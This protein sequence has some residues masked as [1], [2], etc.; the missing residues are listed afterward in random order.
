MSPAEA[1]SN[2]AAVIVAAGAGRRMGAVT[3]KQYLA[4]AGEPI[5]FH[6]LRAFDACAVIGAITLVAPVDELE[7][8][9]ANIVAPLGLATPVTLCPGGRERQDSVRL[10]LAAVDA[11]H[12]LVAIHDGVRP[13]IQSDQI[14][15]CLAAAALHGAALLAI[16]VSDTL[17][18]ADH[19]RKVRKTLPRDGVWLAQ[20]PQA[21]ER[22][23]IVAA[24]QRADADGIRGTDDAALVERLGRSV[25]LVNGSRQNIKVTTPEDLTL[26]EAFLGVSAV[27]PGT[28]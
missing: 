10:G 21:F 15:A 6:T 12:R 1:I 22:R 24:H 18:L 27:R 25:H 17:K 7:W 19:D 16:P 2:S 28:Y 20:T 9:K 8:V 14:E 4:L 13:L 5:L 23:L 3:R 26:A 11:S